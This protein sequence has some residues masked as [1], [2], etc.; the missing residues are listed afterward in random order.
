[1]GFLSQSGYAID[2]GTAVGDC[3]GIHPE[4]SLAYYPVSA[5]NFRLVE[6]STPS[7]YID[8]GDRKLVKIYS[9]D[10][11]SLFLYADG[12]R[13]NP[14]NTSGVTYL[15]IYNNQ[16]TWMPS[17]NFLFMKVGVSGDK[18]L[19]TVWANIDGYLTDATDLA[20]NSNG[21]VKNSNYIWDGMWARL[22][23]EA[24]QS[25][26]SVFSFR[27]IETGANDFLI[28]TATGRY[29]RIHNGI[30]VVSSE[31]QRFNIV[32]MEPGL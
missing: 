23:Y 3:N 13:V 25:N 9:T 26:N 29:I 18:I 30:P 15:G 5:S 2:P 32:D 28:E 16:N 6:P 27:R 12:S 10:N 24:V 1:M 11:P 19:Y 21:S 14:L 4:A 17:D 7:Q 22:S 31:G 20:F 8:F